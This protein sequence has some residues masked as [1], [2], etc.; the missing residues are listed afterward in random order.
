[1]SRAFITTLINPDQFITD[2]NNGTSVTTQRALD[3]RVIVPNTPGEY[4]V[5]FYSHGHTA[6]TPGTGS[7][8][9]RALADRGY[10]VIVPTHLDSVATPIAIR[11]AYP[12]ENPA[13]TLHRV[14][15]M[16]YAFDKLHE[17][18]ALAPG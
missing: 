11:D 15:D 10:I 12:L 6:Y 8:N 1:M 14:A 4:P 16:Q 18:M 2:T 9:A 5:V 3:M 13:S 7:L 17:L